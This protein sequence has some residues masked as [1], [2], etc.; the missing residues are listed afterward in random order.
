MARAESKLSSGRFSIFYRSSNTYDVVHYCTL[1]DACLYETWLFHWSISY[2]SY[3]CLQ[4]VLS[5][6]VS[7]SYDE[8]SL[9]LRQMLDR[10]CYCC[11]EVWFP[12]VWCIVLVSFETPHR[13]RTTK[14]MHLKESYLQPQGR[15]NKKQFCLVTTTFFSSCQCYVCF[16]SDQWQSYYQLELFWGCRK[17]NQKQGPLA[18]SLAAHHEWLSVKDSLTICVLFYFLYRLSQ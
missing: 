1:M 17:W 16:Y 14:N 18:S 15:S 12:L 10:N 13:D 9:V 11:F 8:I 3:D 2:C 5:V 7:V 6:L 4:A